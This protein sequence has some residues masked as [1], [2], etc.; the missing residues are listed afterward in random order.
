MNEFYHEMSFGFNWWY[1]VGPLLMILMFF[2]GASRFSLNKSTLKIRRK[3]E[4]RFHLSVMAGVSDLILC[5]LILRESFLG[6]LQAIVNSLGDSDI[7]WIPIL[8]AFAV[9]GMVIF[10]YYVLYGCGRLGMKLTY[11]YLKALRRELLTINGL[12]M[13]ERVARK[14]CDRKFVMPTLDPDFSKVTIM[15]PDMVEIIPPDHDF[16]YNFNSTF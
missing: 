7:A 16:S 10:S 11:K 3:R 12:K 6:L 14:H 2:V 15:D 4:N 1:L 5:I 9:L 8:V 13:A